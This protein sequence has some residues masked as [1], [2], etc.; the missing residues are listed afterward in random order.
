ME[1]RTGISIRPVSGAQDLKTFIRLPHAIYADDPAWVPPLDIERKMHLSPRHNPFFNHGEAQLFIA[2]A[3]SQPVGRVSAHVN[4]LHLRTHGDDTGFFGF[5]EGMDDPAIF[6]ALLEEAAN[7]LRAHGMKRMRGPFSF[8]INEESGLLVQGFDTPPAFLMGHARQWYDAHVKAA[9]LEKVMDLYAYDFDDS[10]RP[11]EKATRL[12]GRLID[13]GDLVIRRMN[14]KRLREELDI[15]M[16][17]FNDAWSQNWGFIPFTAEEIRKL[18]D[19]LKFLIRERNVLIAEYRGEPAAMA[20][21]MPD[22]NRWIAGFRGRLLP[23]NWARFLYHLW[24]AGPPER[25]RMP[26]MGVRRKFHKGPLGAGIAIAVINQIWRDHAE[27]GVKS[28]ELSWVLETNH[29]VRNI[30]E[31]LGGRHYKTY[32]IYEKAIA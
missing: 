24:F 6:A 32:R 15:I 19:D 10:A 27:W 30:I 31:S 5:I 21:V 1:K 22:I 13:K 12:A 4:H 7:W 26:L 3:D 2:Y 8:S 20:V 17:I 25:M 11:H 18:G 16:G 23:F 29:A 14:K 9:G 28:A